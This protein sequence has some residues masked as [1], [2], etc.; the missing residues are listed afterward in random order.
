MFTREDFLI[1]SLLRPGALIQRTMT[2]NPATLMP[3][4]V[5]PATDTVRAES[6]VAPYS[7]PNELDD[8]GRETDEMR[9]AYRDFHR[10]EPA[11]RAA[12]EGMVASIGDTDVAVIP[13]DEDNDD[14]C[15]AAEL[16]QYAVESSPHG[17]DGLIRR[18]LLGALIDG[19]SVSEKVLCGIENHRRWGGFWGLKYVKSKDTDH[20]RLRLDVYR[21]IIGVVNTVRG[22]ATYPARKMVIFTHADVYDNPFGSSELRACYRACQLIENAY[23]L[24]AFALNAYSGPFLKGKV[25]N[26]ERRQ[27]MEAALK[28]ARAGG[29]V[30][31][32]KDDE[33]DL[34]NLASASSFDAFERKIDKLREEIYI[35]IRG[36]YLPFMQGTGGGGETRGNADTS[37]GAGSDPRERVI[38]KAIGRCLTHQL[39]PDLVVPNFGTRC[40]IPR[41]VLGGVDWNETKA[42][43]D[44]AKSVLNDFRVPIS[45]AWLYKSAQTPPPMSEEDAIVPPAAPQMNPQANPFGFGQGG[46]G[47]PPAT[48]RGE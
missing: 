19:F 17:W 44:V 24:W 35:A 34:I 18:V 29:Y 22:I 23:K 16:V 47:N 3:Q 28:A 20:L 48:F 46:A 21:N 32:P 31:T 42:Q 10:K 15:R 39:C 26:N 36:A 41:I 25:A 5:E 8:Y 38:A 14:D 37:K 30:V 27:Q 2:A 11:V 43:L 40:G 7:A 6:W 45:K 9:R 33:V 1:G 13:D 4:P 12:I